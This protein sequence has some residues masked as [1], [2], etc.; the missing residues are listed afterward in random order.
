M[1]ERILY[2]TTEC[3]I[4]KLKIRVVQFLP[5]LFKQLEYEIRIF[6]LKKIKRKISSKSGSNED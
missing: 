2:Y 3:D 4:M 5:R 1:Y 6:N